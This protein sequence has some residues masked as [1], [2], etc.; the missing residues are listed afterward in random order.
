MHFSFVSTPMS[1]QFCEP[2]RGRRKNWRG[3][4]AGRRRFSPAMPPR[5]SAAR[6][7]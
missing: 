3:E 5:D 2:A 4:L 6:S 1:F 7:M